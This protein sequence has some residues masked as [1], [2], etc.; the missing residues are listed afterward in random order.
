MKQ[1]FLLLLSLVAAGVSRPL[2]A[3]ALTAPTYSWAHLP[4]AQLPT[5]KADTFNITAYGAKPD[6][7]TLNTQSINAAIATCS[8]N[9]GGVVLVPQ[10]LWLTGPL[11]LKSNVNLHLVRA[12]VLQFTPDFNQYSL[13]LGSFEGKPSYR[14]QSPLSGTGL[15]NVAITGHGIVDGNGD[16]WRMVG[17]D[18]LTEREWKNKVAAG[19]L[20]SEDG[21][22]WYPSEKTRLGSKTFNAGDVV[23]GKTMQDYIP[24]KDFLRPNL[25]VLTNCKKVLLDGVTFQNSPAWCLH[26][27]LCEDLTVRNVLTRNPDYAQNGDGLDVESCRNIL[28]EGCTFDVGDDGICIKSGKDEEGRKRGVPTENAVIRRNVVYRAHGGFVIGSEMSG[29]ARNLFVED[30]TFIGTDIGLR[31]K[32]ARGRGGVVENIFVRNIAMKD[33]VHDAILFDMYYFMKPPAKLADGQ[34]APEAIPAV[35]E[36]TPRFRNFIL[37]NIVCDGAERGLFLRGLPEMSVQ[38]IHLDNLVLKA[39]KGVELIEAQDIQISNLRLETTAAAPVV[40]V[41]NSRNI[42]FDGLQV[43]APSTQPLFSVSGRRSE[44]ITAVRTAAGPS[45]TAIEAKAGASAKAVKIVKVKS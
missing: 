1:A 11:T 9:G 2:R 31:F 40:Y 7:R 32:T 16:A 30:C 26:P 8:S 14:N 4:T 19:G 29:G 15:T 36:A 35:T 42:S 22:T 44:K 12:A 34:A 13:V 45:R 17:R 28:I 27:L 3:Q 5:F 38:Q 33:I 21:K 41:E 43:A 20:V 24:I 10:G 6:G 25:L 37:S 18:R 39:N 23:P